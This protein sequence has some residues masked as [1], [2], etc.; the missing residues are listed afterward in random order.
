MLPASLDFFEHHPHHRA[1]VFGRIDDCKPYIGSLPPNLTFRSCEGDL[2]AGLNPA[3]LLR[4]DYNSAIE[5]A[6]QCL[7]NQEADALVSSEHTGVLM[8]LLHRHSLVHPA[9]ERPALVSWVPTARQPVLMLDLGASFSAT[10]E[11][12]LGFAAAG[13]AIAS[14]RSSRKPRLALLNLGVEANKGPPAL[15]LAAE[16]LAQWSDVDFCGFAEANTIFRGDYDLIITDGFTGNAVIKSAEGTVDL[17]LSA[18]RQQ[19]GGDLLGKAL[20]WVLGRRLQPLLNQLDPRQSN[21]ALLAGTSLTL[22]KS[23]GHADALAF[24]AAI[25][26]AIEASEGGWSQRVLRRLDPLL[27]D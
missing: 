9:L 6:V 5:A 16:R 15:H 1:I 21:G 22:I 18:L 11:Q 10:T 20:G 25:I 17:L 7:A 8:T 26:R 2:P 23:H 13:I 3:R 4:H 14:D 24:K 12:L 19:L 27:V